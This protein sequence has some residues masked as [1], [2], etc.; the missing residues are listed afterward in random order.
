MKDEE[1]EMFTWLLNQIT[2]W[3]KTRILY[4]KKGLD[5]DWVNERMDS[6]IGK[7]KQIYWL[8]YMKN[9]KHYQKQ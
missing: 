1:E 8:F 9:K 2:K 3:E 7:D 4:L 5:P 6:F